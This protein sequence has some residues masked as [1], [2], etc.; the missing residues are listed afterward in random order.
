M[1]VIVNI[2]MSGPG[3]SW[4]KGQR[5]ECSEAEAARL[6]ASGAA[7]PVP[8][9]EPEPKPKAAAKKRSKRVSKAVVEPSERAVSRK[10]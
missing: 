4:R 8:E 9:S 3:G 10:G 5:Y 7:S 1:Q 2:S 6:V